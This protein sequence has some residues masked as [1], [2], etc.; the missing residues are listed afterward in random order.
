MKGLVV[1]S[2]EKGEGVKTVKALV[3]RA[4][5]SS[6]LFYPLRER[7]YFRNDP[8]I[9][10]RRRRQ[11]EFYRGLLGSTRLI[12]DVGANVGQR[13]AIFVALGKR[14]VA[15]EPDTRALAQLRARFR[16]VRKVVI[17]GI[18]LG[19]KDDELPLY[20][21]ETDA[22][23]SLSAEH[24][25]MMHDVHFPKDEWQPGQA[26]QVATLD[27]MTKKHGVPGFIKIDV[28][29]FELEVLKG[30][31]TPV[32]LSF[33]WHGCRASDI[34]QRA[35]RLHELSADYRFNYCL[36]EEVAFALPESVGYQTLVQKV[37][38]D[39]A[40]RS[41]R[42]ATFMR[43][44]T[45]GSQQVLKVTKTL[46]TI[47]RALRFGYIPKSVSYRV[48][49]SAT[50]AHT[51]ESFFFKTALFQKPLTYGGVCGASD[52]ALF[53]DL[54]KNEVDVIP[55]LSSVL[56]A[57]S[58]PTVLDVGANNGAFMVVVKALNPLAKVHCFEPFP[59]LA[60]FLSDLVEQ[61]CFDNVVVN[62]SL[63]GES[64]GPQPLYFTQGS[65]VT[66][67]VVKDFQETFDSQLEAMQCRLDSYV[68]EKAL[69]R[70]SLIKIDVEGGELEVL[71]GARRT[72]ETMRP[73]IL[74][75][76]LYTENEGHKKRQNE[77]VRDLK[78]LGYRF[79]QIR[80]QGELFYQ[81]PVTPDHGYRFLNYLVTPN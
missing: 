78:D 47:G 74:M 80:E 28:E 42:G 24:V 35:A 67:S 4:L 5:R 72:I 48:W 44:L 63:V 15:F 19:S 61:N 10:G 1:A 9:G 46:N 7:L 3:R 51:G 22:L 17:E 2:P 75:E 29:G 20:V 49:R 31:S 56:K 53:L 45:E 69:G 43:C 8:E 38:P 12:F 77:V 41:T 37:I 23:S 57:E 71:K 70:V 68:E 16:F 40:L 25:R 73:N 79:F 64:N 52:D 30:L 60:S 55:V 13:T 26:V 33:E 32:S 11:I 39:L 54:E 62:N 50:R 76:L 27:A 59:Q 34:A 81:D 18:A 6:G 66:A 65:T 14:V 58:A 36:G 21:C